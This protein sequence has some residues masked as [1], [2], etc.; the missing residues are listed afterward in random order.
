MKTV[1]FVTIVTY[2]FLSYSKP[3]QGSNGSP[4]KSNN[5]PES[6]IFK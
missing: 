1:L 4:R 6:S 2:A 3:Y 5:L